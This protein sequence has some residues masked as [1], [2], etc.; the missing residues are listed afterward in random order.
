MK[1]PSL[2][3]KQNLFFLIAIFILVMIFCSFAGSISSMFNT[4]EGYRPL[5]FG[6]DDAAAAAAQKQQ[7]INKCNGYKEI[8][9]TKPYHVISYKK[10][11]AKVGITW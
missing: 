7:L 3:K 10:S 1:F 4:V 9:K 5:R 8:A 2:V 11:C 6:N